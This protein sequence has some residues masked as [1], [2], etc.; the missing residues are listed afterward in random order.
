M[1]GIPTGVNYQLAWDAQK[2]TEDRL[3]VVG[4]TGAINIS[5]NMLDLEQAWK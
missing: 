4:I 5:D 2:V 3:K 1:D